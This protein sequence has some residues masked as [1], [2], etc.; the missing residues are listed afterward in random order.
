L[1]YKSVFAK[2]VFVI[3]FILGIILQ[4]DSARAYKLPPGGSSLILKLAPG[5][6]GSEQ[7][8]VISAYG[9][10]K[11][12]HLQ[13]LKLHVVHMAQGDLQDALARYKSD[14]RVESVEVDQVRS[15]S[16]V[17]NDTL[18][19]SQWSLP[20]IGWDQVFG[21][22]A[23]TGTA[24][25]ALLDAGIDATHPDL[26]G[27]VVSGISILD[28]SNGLTDATGH[29]TMMA[30]IV[31]GVAGNGTGIA[32]VAP[33]GVKVMPVTV[34]DA[35]G[36]GRDSD[37]IAGIIW[38]ADHGA[39]VILMPFSNPGF[40]QSL[41]DAIDY[42]WSKGAVLIAATGN[43]G[44][45]DPTYPAGDR[46]VVAV[47]AS[48]RND[49]LYGNSNFGPETYLAAPGVEI[50]STSR[51]GRYAEITGTSASSAIVAGIA[52]F[53]KAVD[54]TLTNGVIVGRLGRTAEQLGSETLPGNGRVNMAAALAD[55]SMIPVQPAGVESSL[56]FEDPYLAAAACTSLAFTSVPYVSVVGTVSGEMTVSARN[57]NFR[58]TLNP[59]QIYV[60][61]SS[62]SPSYKF[63]SDQSGTTEITAATMVSGE[64]T[65]ETNNTTHT[66]TFFYKDMS[67]G[68]PTTTGSM[69]GLAPATQV[70]TINKA[71]QVIS[72][73]STPPADAKVAG[74]GYTP[75]VS[76]G[77]SGIPVILTIDATAGSV[78]SVSGGTVSFQQV[79]SCVINANQQGDLNYNPASQVQQSF[80]VG[81]G[82]QA[83][84]TA[85]VTPSTV[86]YGATAQLGITG[87]SGSGEVSY[88]AAGSTGCS[89][90]G[91]TLSVVNPGGTCSVTG[92]KAGDN[93]YHA[94]TSA[95]LPV[96]LVKGNQEP[97]T[98]AVPASAIFGQ[99]GLFATASGG[100]GTGTYSYSAGGSVACSVDAA[101]GAM[102]I[103]AASGSCSITAIR[104]AD[105]NY[106][107]SQ[108]SAAASFSVGKAEQ[109]T[110]TASVTPATI[111]YGG[112]AS[113][114]NSGGSGFGAVTYSAGGSTGCSVSGSQLS[115]TDASGTCSITATKAEDEN[116]NAATSIAVQVTLV[117]AAQSA[118]AVS[119]PASATFAQAGL[120]ATASGGS[121]GGA[122]SFSAGGST[123]CSVD[124]ST[125]ALSITAATGTCAIT[126]TRGGDTNY[127]VSAPS[128]A[129]SLSVSKA[130]QTALVATATPATVAFGGT[131]SLGVTGGSG[132]GAITYSAGA[133]T[134][135]SLS[136]N[137]LSV[138]SAGG[139][140]S[141]TATKEGDDN[142]HAA[143]S[144][145][146]TVEL[147]KGVQA[148]VTLSAPTVA[149]Y[150][151]I[152]LFAV[153]GGG[154]GIGAFNYYA[155]SSDACEVD[156]ATGALIITA[157]TG[158]C[159]IRATR[160]GDVNY[161]VSL[162]SAAASIAVGK[163]EQETLSAT[164]TPSTLS[165]GSSAQ[166]G[167]TGGSG[168]GGITYSAGGST[169][170]AVSGSTLSVTSAGGTCSVSATKAA[171]IN[172]H[173]ATSAEFPVTL[174][175]GT[176]AVVTVS[177]PVS[178]LFLQTGLTAS[179]SGGNGSGSYRFDAGSSDACSVSPSGEITITAGTGDCEITATRESDGNYLASAA[180]APVT[181][182]I[183]KASQTISFT[184]PQSRTYGAADFGAG[185]TASSGLEVTYSSDK[186][187]V[188]SITAGGLVHIV[189]E[190]TAT[191]SAHQAGDADYTAALKVQQTL[192]VNK[193]LLTVTAN[194][195]S[196][197]Y[198][199]EEPPFSASYAGF[200]NGDDAA[201]VIGAPAFST[202]AD[203]YSPVGSYPIIPSLGTLEAA[204]YS[205]SFAQGTLAVGLASQ[206]IT[207]NALPVQ[208]YGA[209]A[210]FDL[211]FTPGASGNPVSFTSSNP[212]VATVS[213]STVTIVGAGDT[214]IVAQQPGDTNYASATA[215]QTLTVAKAP[216]AVTAQNA[217]RPYKAEEP[218]FT[219]SYSGFVKDEDET[220]LSGAPIIATTALFESA[221]GSYPIT[222]IQGSLTAANYSFTFVPGTLAIGKASQTISFDTLAARTYGDPVF[223]LSAKGGDSGN[224]VSFTSSNPAVATVSGATVTILGA[225]S[226]NIVAGQS[227]DANYAPATAQQTLTVAR[228]V[229]SVSADPATRPYN[230]ENPPFTVTY[231]GFAY[232][233]NASLLAGAPALSSTAGI[234]SPPGSYPIIPEVGNLFSANYDFSLADG[235]L[236]VVKGDQ[237]SVTVT[238]PAAATFGQAGLSV[239]AGGGSGTGAY[240]FQ[241]GSSTACTVD[242]LSGALTVTSGTGSCTITATRG[243][244]S[245]Y[246]LSASSAA[247][248]ISILKANQ[249]QVTVTA[250]ETLEYGSTAV[251]SA[252]GGS[253]T[254]VMA[255][256]ADG[257]TGCLVEGSTLSVTDASGTCSV[258]ATRAADN[259][260]NA[261]TSAPAAVMLVKT[262]QA[263]VTLTAPPAAIYAQSGL[264]VGAGG[265]SGTGAYNYHAGSSTACSVH[266][267]TGA[268]TIFSGSG[269]CE[270]SATKAE[271]R[272]YRVSAASALAK[273][274]VERANQAA[275]AVTAPSTLVY[276]GTASLAID[277]GSGSGEVTYSTGGSTG[278]SV[279]G[280]TLSVNNAVGTC[281]V[282]A[283]KAQ[284]SNY[285]AATSMA[286]SVTLM[287][288]TPAIAWPQPANITIGTALSVAQ[289]K[290]TASPVVGT[291]VYT[292]A[293]GTKLRVGPG[294]TLSVLFLPTDAVNYA[295]ASKSVSITVD[296]AT[297]PVAIAGKP[298]GS[299]DGIKTG[300][301]FTVTRTEVAN[302]ANAVTIVTAD[303]NFVD[304]SVLKPNTIYQYAVASDTD[305]AKIIFM[306]VRTALYKGWNIVALP[307]ET[308]GI[309]ATEFFAQPINGVYQWNPTGTTEES[310]AKQLGS[311]ANVTELAP[312]LGYFAKTSNSS[313]MLFHAGTPGPASAT[314]TLKPGWTMIA[315]PNI[316]NKTDIGAKWLIDGVPLSFFINAGKIGGSVYWWNGTAYDS[317]TIMNDNPQI[318]PWK[319]YWVINLDSVNHTLTIQ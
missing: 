126:A 32:G 89:I 10:N 184:A 142:Y 2:P 29:G 6:S 176:Q 293:A 75:A 243:G 295:T 227:G 35:D 220:V 49:N 247:A 135:C 9:G 208:T 284:D 47:C 101:T 64:R 302:P 111:T 217:S 150:G 34:L 95:A 161:N 246:N 140:C 238:A 71:D 262:T 304:N 16:G 175:K 178:A 312:G 109:A 108:A 145:A 242:A 102:T 248:T 236:T 104:S 215:K 138:I 280:N 179:A 42:A 58:C 79:G 298:S 214:E 127:L 112:T 33:G 147:I 66:A 97:V 188:A 94:A 229:L 297:T 259:N 261:T 177:A 22:T 292:P 123:A 77:S 232:S 257:S 218:A 222:L 36:S 100:S 182:A 5:L 291:Y 299:Y 51:W 120:F 45:G 274:P 3:T 85:T 203:I 50:Y 266:G 173:A 285:N 237:A 156:L 221:V 125:G 245:N 76:G 278:C 193:A 263:P 113:L 63:Y 282:T 4:V 44:S 307:Y 204:N 53:L 199:T 273:I 186:P 74:A 103:T 62:S 277:G 70:Q 21:V 268:L 116:Y 90:S 114:G 250:P 86:A 129:A 131:A 80:P 319:G 249:T 163:A 119:V 143:T 296:E 309:A 117:K 153:A 69:A 228:K 311:Y 144:G 137:T 213:G 224:P 27:R 241:A 68:S 87:G 267:L 183:N 149:A 316:T 270:I 83:T 219:F 310:S 252:F 254:G 318:E 172:Y 19:P 212:A 25:V 189:G 185:A 216:L 231:S 146:L 315:N 255:Y 195:A 256:S 148:T 239:S 105:L 187:E 281:S 283:A 303:A 139:T 271:D 46:G 313:T 13:R 180:S 233:D 107:I 159:D 244:D 48:D 132:L 251:L 26:A 160:A 314:I 30:G 300:N 82:S 269:I 54:P 81:M 96:T 122:Y 24:T 134:G 308:T 164:V 207:F 73:A 206:T 106:N 286:A 31:A 305:P 43:G 272:N 301:T 67:A 12:A 198:N 118:V 226:A 275:L 78:C 154:S 225:G 194:N 37:I 52:S 7:E 56:P 235:I 202:S 65:D 279:A 209:A 20:K 121:G 197:S 18:Y 253:S 28:G 23:P 60:A 39:D 167:A 14:P 15:A 41:Q 99:P 115:V 57:G 170:C 223:G 8:R 200:V 72:F 40:S 128:A 88:S 158:S 61:L 157:S 287:K 289:L 181:V 258:T 110:L 276:R 288:A 98:V 171:D 93:D 152:G 211:G 205:F 141:V 174:V 260:Y 165:Y 136:G 91:T 201:V 191:I 133:S 240:S 306:T 92:T 130:V 192:S 265:G 55:T 196:R 234:S 84:L 317:W 59:G 168:S 166:L 11:K 290:A 151:E 162:A 294:Q 190:G 169:G 38:A 230:R 155:G 264:S 17:S 210:G 1:N 124:G